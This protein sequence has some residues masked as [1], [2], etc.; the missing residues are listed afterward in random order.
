MTK[1]HGFIKGALVSTL[2]TGVLIL[3]PGNTEAAQS[4][5]VQPGDSLW[6]IANNFSISISQLKDYNNLSSDEIWVGQKLVIPGGN[7]HY[8]TV[9][10]GDSL[11]FIAQAKAV[12]VQQL[13]IANQLSGDE[14]WV[15]QQLVIPKPAESSSSS[16]QYTVVPGDSLYLIAQRYGT[17]VDK[18][19][20]INNLTNHNLYVG[21]VLTLSA[22]NTPVPAPAPANPNTGW[23]LPQGVTL[24]YVQSGDS[25]GSIAQKYRSSVDAV[26][27]TN[28]L[29]GELITPGMPLFVPVNS[30]QPVTINA[31]QGAKKAGYGEL[32]SWEYANWLFNHGSTGVVKDLQTGATFNISRIGGGNHAD[33]EPLTAQDTAVMKDLFGGSWSWQ[34]RPVILIYQGREIAA[35]MAGMPHG[36]DTIGNNN[37][38]GMFDLHFLGS[39]THNTNTEDPQH[40]QSVL[41]AAGK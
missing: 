5:S 29:K 38:V 16:S 18:L 1:K 36:F 31:P 3:S 2:I 28:R 12:T 15:G 34:V 24:H 10:P 35:S 13:K 30:S 19:M 25:L 20:S 14:I 39:R 11:Y 21:Q 27:K 26:L 8:Y 9:Q 6:K 23:Q 17:S 37:F 33:C 22:G 7:E 32:L 40:Q 41:K 4:Y